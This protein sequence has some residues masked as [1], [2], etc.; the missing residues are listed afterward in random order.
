M[1]SGGR[2]LHHLH[3]RLGDP[4]AT[5]IFAGYQSAGTLGYLM[6]HGAHTI[7]IFGDSVP[8]KADVVHLSGFSAHADQNDLKR[9]FGT[10]TTKPRLYAVHGEVESATA[11]ATLATAA[12]G[13]E[14]S[15]AR[16]GT[17]VTL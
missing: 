12:F 2:I 1:A 8:I 7:R 11:V 17:T 16:R 6:I 14:A 15:V 4:T 13:W 9:W 3:E 5:V 10:C